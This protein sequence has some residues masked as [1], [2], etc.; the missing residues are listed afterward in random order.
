MESIEGNKLIAEFMEMKDSSL[1]YDIP[2]SFRCH[3]THC[4]DDDFMFH[5]SWDWLMPVVEKI[6][7]VWWSD[8]EN[9]W[10]NVDEEELEDRKNDVLLLTI[11]VPIKEVW[12]SI[13]QFI[14]WFNSSNTKQK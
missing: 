11:S 8:F 7:K 6:G 10:D 12:K 9:G 5:S 1:G 4:E 14:Q 2:D 13:V 3:W